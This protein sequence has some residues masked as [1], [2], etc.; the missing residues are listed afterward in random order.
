MTRHIVFAV[1]AFLVCSGCA[2]GPKYQQPSAAPPL[3][4]KE[5][6]GNDDWKMAT[7]SDQLLKGK[8]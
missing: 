6:V 1:L 4:F 3:P 7:P 2:I 5:L 8:W